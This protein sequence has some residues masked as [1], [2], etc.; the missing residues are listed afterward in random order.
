MA[1]RAS[2]SKGLVPVT[3]SLNNIRQ[4][5]DHLYWSRMEQTSVFQEN[6]IITS[7]AFLPI[8][9]YYVATTSAFRLT[10]YDTVVCDSVS[11]NS[12]FNTQVFG[13]TY[14]NDGSL[15]GC[16][17]LDGTVRLYDVHKKDAQLRTALRTIKSDG[18]PAHVV[19]FSSSGHKVAAMNDKGVF[20]VYDVADTSG[21]SLLHMVAHE[22]HIRCG[23]FSKINEHLLATGSYDHTVKLWDTRS[24]RKDSVLTVDHGFPVEKVILFPNDNIMATAGGQVVKLWDIASSYR[25]LTMLEHHHKTVTAMCLA[26]NNRKLLTAGLD[27]RINVFKVDSGDYDLVYQ[28]STLA[29]VMT[30]AMSPNDDC[31]VYGMQNIVAINRRKAASKEDKQSSSLKIAQKETKTKSMHRVFT[32][33]AEGQKVRVVM[34]A[35]MLDKM[36]LGTIDNLVNSKKFNKVIEVLFMQSKNW[37]E[38]AALTVSALRQIYFNKELRRALTGR[39]ERIMTN[40]FLFLKLNLFNTAYFSTLIKVAECLIDIYSEESDFSDVTKKHFQDLKR[41]V[42]CELKREGELLRIRGMLEVIFTANKR[43]LKNVDNVES[44]ECDLFGEM[45]INPISLNSLS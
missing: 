37:V 30:L 31:M 11:V 21:K 19:S 1:N 42:D 33:D 41:I 4:S 15:L 28:M 25:E 23:A 39:D 18:S 44:N 38:N 27:R 20:N 26:S 9:P 17:S 34:T 6:G 45:M 32:Q 7:T 10:V 35:P 8:S 16:G 22:D 3:E 43:Q 40:V 29:P 24:D 12:R 2:Y 13:A 36:N 5:D 14:R